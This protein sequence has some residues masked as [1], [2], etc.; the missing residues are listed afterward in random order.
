MPLVPNGLDGSDSMAG[1][2]RPGAD[3][4]PGA[5]RAFLLLDFR[6][7]RSMRLALRPTH[8]LR[9]VIVESSYAPTRHAAKVADWIEVTALRRGTSLG[10]QALQDLGKEV[11]VSAADIA[12]GMTIERG[13]RICSSRPTRSWMGPVSLH[14][15]RTVVERVLLF[16]ND[17]G[18]LTE[19]VD[20]ASH[21]R[22]VGELP[23]G[24]EPHRAGQ[25]G[26]GDQPGRER[27]RCAQP[28]RPGRGV[29]RRRG[30]YIDSDSCDSASMG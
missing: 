13:L 25:R 10:A 9:H 30:S 22:A 26:V 6:Q 29:R 17:V 1:P 11:G 2:W 16:L 15:A 5:L 19:E 8:S 4:C 20:P 14:R 12:L 28:D 24:V 7:H 3:A 21:R 27:E 18:L 23:A